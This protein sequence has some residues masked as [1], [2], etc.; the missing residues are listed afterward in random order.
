MNIKDMI[1]RRRDDR[2]QKL[3]AH[4]TTMNRMTDAL[5]GLNFTVQEPCYSQDSFSEGIVTFIH[6]NITIKIKCIATEADYYRMQYLVPPNNAGDWTSSVNLQKACKQIV[7]YISKYED[8]Q[9]T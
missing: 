4:W 7:D 9:N 1:Q 8:Q 5:I 2:Q 3:R 6:D